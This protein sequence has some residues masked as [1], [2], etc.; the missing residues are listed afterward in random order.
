MRSMLGLYL[1]VFEVFHF[2]QRL[3]ISSLLL[4]SPPPELPDPLPSFEDDLNTGVVDTFLLTSTIKLFDV[5]KFEQ[6]LIEMGNI[7]L[8]IAWCEDVNALPKTSRILFLA[9]VFAKEARREEGNILIF[10]E[11]KNGE[12]VLQHKNQRGKK[13]S[14]LW[15]NAI[16]I[17]RVVERLRRRG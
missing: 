12:S 11:N 7:T 4:P 17:G 9:A 10:I 14:L 5:D 16:S 8:F 13:L 1:K 6:P 3:I 2:I 15:H